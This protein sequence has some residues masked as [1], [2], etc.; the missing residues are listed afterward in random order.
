MTYFLTLGWN[1]RLSWP[2]SPAY[3]LAYVLS[4]LC[5]KKSRKGMFDLQPSALSVAHLI[6]VCYTGAKQEK[7]S[8]ISCCS[9]HV[10]CCFDSG[11][12][13]SRSTWGPPLKY[14]SP[15]AL[16]P[17]CNIGW[18]NCN[19]GHSTMQRLLF[20]FWTI[21]SRIFIWGKNRCFAS[22][23]MFNLSGVYAKHI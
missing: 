21:L 11:K 5:S 10:L 17:F 1:A 22:P 7:P 16:H 8:S 23:Y 12:A 19:T 18:Q 14:A 9:W 15:A 20:V 4:L 13:R 6:V 3:L 2:L